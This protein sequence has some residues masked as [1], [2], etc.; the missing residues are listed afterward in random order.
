MAPTM[1][2][3]TRRPVTSD[4]IERELARSRR[5]A[6]SAGVRTHV[7]D[8]IAYADQATLAAELADAIAQ[9]EVNR[10]SRALIAQG[11]PRARHVT[12]DTAVFCG[13]S[14]ATSAVICLEL[15]RLRGPSTSDALPS[16]IASLTVPDL[17]VFVFWLAPLDPTRDVFRALRRVATRLVTD[18]VREPET[19]D[20]LLPLLDEDTEVVT[21][22]AWTKITG[23]REV[24]ASIFDDAA[25]HQSPRRLSQVAIRYV[26]GSDTQARLMAGWLAARTATQPRVVLEPVAVADMRAGSLVAVELDCGRE[27]FAVERPQEGVAVIHAPRRSARK[28][29]LRVPAFPRLIGEELEFLTRDFAF[30]DALRAAVAASGRIHAGA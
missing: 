26:T 17:P 28:I 12:A 21:D 2:T 5:E 15:V 13:R 19:L 11:S 6:A 8:L 1:T 24:V 4:E 10:P 29:A 20:R 30:Q 22:L 27:H 23:W 9:L 14:A 18:S 7:V 25:F 16:L 3:R